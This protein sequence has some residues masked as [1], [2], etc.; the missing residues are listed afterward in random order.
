MIR[1]R[2]LRKSFG[3]RTALDGIDA[4]APEGAVVA[5]VGPSGSGK[6]T[7]LR[8]LNALESFERGTV[9]V[10]GFRLEPGGTARPDELARLRAHV[11]MVFQD[12]HLFPH[13]SVLDN[14]TLA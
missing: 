13:L 7:L 2:G 9:E 4:D 12:L 10:A 8:C 1:I 14:V 5:L 3:E 6:S 11:G